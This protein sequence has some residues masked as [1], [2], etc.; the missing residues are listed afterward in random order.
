MQWY[1]RPTSSKSSLSLAASVSIS[2]IR[3]YAQ[4]DI[5][6]LMLQLK[7]CEHH[8]QY[9]SSCLNLNQ[10]HQ[11]MRTAWLLK[12]VLTKQIQ[13]LGTCM[14]AA[15]QDA[16]KVQTDYTCHQHGHQLMCKAS[17]VSSGNMSTR[18]ASESIRQPD[19]QCLKSTPAHTSAMLSRT[20]NRGRPKLSCLHCSTA[21]CN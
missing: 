18:E 16:A 13:L 6:P 14:S 17:S 10:C 11:G 12:V 15:A 19:C 2:A 5:L 8:I 9:S 3:A 4:P 21:C 1:H 7:H 20:D